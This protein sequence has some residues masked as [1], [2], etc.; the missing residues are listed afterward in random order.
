M[1]R[2]SLIVQ[3]IARTAWRWLREWSGDAAYDS[4]VRRAAR[5]QPGKPPLAPAEFYLE[6]IE[7][8][9]SRPNRC[10]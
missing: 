1:P 3:R 2:L 10:C 8:R 5:V 4:Y 7:R 9:Y 6:Q